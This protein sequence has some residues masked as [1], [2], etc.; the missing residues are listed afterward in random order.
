[1]K[2]G[3]IYK[4]KI[5]GE[6]F[7]VT[8][9]SEVDPD[10]GVGISTT[11]VVKTFIDSAGSQLIAEYDTW[12]KAVNSSEFK[13]TE[14][15][16]WKDLRKV[17]SDMG[18]IVADDIFKK[19]HGLGGF[20]FTKDGNVLIILDGKTSFNIANRTPKQMYNILRGLE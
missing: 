3:Q 17:A 5:S 14:V 8:R 19:H 7:C 12:Q 6:V 10:I 18:C 4:H 15:N 13:D 16:T 20:V 2:V 1:M 11:G 9:I